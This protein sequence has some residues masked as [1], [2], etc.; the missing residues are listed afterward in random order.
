MIKPYT[1]YHN[2]SLRVCKL[3]GDHLGFYTD[4][5]VIL[6]KYC[7]KWMPYSKM[8]QNWGITHEYGFKR[9]CVTLRSSGHLHNVLILLIKNRPEVAG[10]ATKLIYLFTHLEH[11]SI[12]KLCM[13]EQCKVSKISSG[14]AVIW[15]ELVTIR[16]C[17][18]TSW[19]SWPMVHPQWSIQKAPLVLF[20]VYSSQDINKGS[21][22]AKSYV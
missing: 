4:S 10:E 19:S 13:P 6:Q 3:N 5:M 7:Q 20:G 14:L 9:S 16:P 22:R 17:A 11:E 2:L 15:G 18:T 21:G 8:P 12:K 1:K